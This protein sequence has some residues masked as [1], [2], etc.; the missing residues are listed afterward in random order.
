MTA[1]GGAAPT[2]DWFG[3]GLVGVWVFI[4]C[5]FRVFLFG[6]FIGPM[7]PGHP[8]GRRAVEPN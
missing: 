7:G 1:L 4:F 6:F 2:N 5:L 3:F 8:G